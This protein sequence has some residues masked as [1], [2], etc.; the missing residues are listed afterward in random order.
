MEGVLV[1]LGWGVE[2]L[3]VVY[4]VGLSML[5]GLGPQEIGLRMM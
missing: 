3:S 5:I 2:V 4:T 1:W